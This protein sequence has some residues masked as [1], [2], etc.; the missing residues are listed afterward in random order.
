M[1]NVDKNIARLSIAQELLKKKK[2]PEISAPDMLS[3]VE[4]RTKKTTNI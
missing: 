1:S 2:P 4:S 3:G